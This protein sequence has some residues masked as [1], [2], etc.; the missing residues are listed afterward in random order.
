[1]RHRTAQHTEH[2]TAL[3]AIACWLAGGETA[4]ASDL[5]P[6]SY[7]SGQASA[8]RT[9]YMRTCAAC[10]GNAL[11]GGAAPG[12]TGAT[13]SH[14]IG[15]PAAD[16]FEYVQLQ[17]PADRPG[18]LTSG[19]VASIL[20]FLAQQNGVPAGGRPVPTNRDGL[21]GLSFGQSATQGG[22]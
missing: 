18:S 7:I 14:W 11:E 22:L 6:M 15:A 5:E 2:L 3:L 4:F 1:M 9:L 19:Q 17:M 10:H 12:L 20:A 16:L 8:G 13:F 21:A